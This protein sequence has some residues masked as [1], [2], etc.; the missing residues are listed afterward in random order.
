MA[1][2]ETRNKEGEEL[3]LRNWN[4][5]DQTVQQSAG[6]GSEAEILASILR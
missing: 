2:G 3:L 5:G 1:K 4:D 6:G